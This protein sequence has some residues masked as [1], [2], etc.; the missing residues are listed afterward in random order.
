M[1][2]IIDGFELREPVI[3]YGP[4]THNKGLVSKPACTLTSGF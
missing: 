1:R 2:D 3:S 4:L